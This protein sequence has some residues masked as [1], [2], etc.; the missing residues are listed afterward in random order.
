MGDVS[1]EYFLSR[2]SRAKS[3]ES[4]SAPLKRQA[5]LG[6]GDR[7][8]RGAKII[9]QIS[10]ARRRIKARAVV[11]RS[12]FATLLSGEKRG[13][14]AASTSPDVESRF[15]A[16]NWRSNLNHRRLG[17]RRNR[18][19]NRLANR[20]IAP[21]PI[22]SPGLA[23]VCRRRGASPLDHSA[24]EAGGVASPHRRKPRKAISCA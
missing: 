14:I 17:C 21:A 24:D 1:G 18:R 3:A 7:A 22:A 8:R 6:V 15:L 13:I 2:L 16:V 12:R 20:G 23:R 19:E 11:G 5:D 10:M 4:A 9:N